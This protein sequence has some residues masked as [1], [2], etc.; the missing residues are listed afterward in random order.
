MNHS[1]HSQRVVY[2]DNAKFALIFLVVAGHFLLPLEHTR[3]SFNIYFLIYTFHMP[4][5]VFLSGF[6]AKTAFKDGHFRIRRLLEPLWLYFLFKLLTHITEGLVAG[7]ITWSIDFFSETGAPWY[8]LAMAL[9]TLTL[10]AFKEL[11]P[12]AVILGSILLSLLSGYQRSVDAFLAMD[13]VLGFAPFFYAGYYLSQKTL[14][15][16]LSAWRLPLIAAAA[17]TAGY[18]GLR[19]Y[20]R[21]GLLYRP[22]F[23]AN[24]TYLDPSLY[25]YGPALRLL[26]Y[27][28]AAL[29]SAGLL[30]AVPRRKTPFSVIGQRTLQ[31]Y[32]LHRLIRDLMQYFGFYQLINVHQKSNVLGLLFLAFLVT[33][34]LG[35]SYFFMVFQAVKNLPFHSSA[36]A[37][38]AKTSSAK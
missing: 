25:L 12:S 8:L 10:P 36:K 18:I 30:A 34:L 1:S 21:L 28:A 7:E 6:F 26:V 2:L 3:F 9:W 33:L 22:I 19:A 14:D 20:D 27:A 38:S 5:F 32:I 4:C 13:R 11:K 37:L 16:V 15:R 24:Y 35:N 31:I 23:S 17:L 29:L